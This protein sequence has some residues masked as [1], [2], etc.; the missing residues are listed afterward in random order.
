TYERLLSQGRVLVMYI[1]QIMLPL[2]RWMPFYYDW[3][4]P[5]RGLMQPWTTL[6]ALLVIAFLFTAAL[7]FRTRS[8]VFS[9]GILIFFASHFVSSNVVGLEL[10]F[11][12]R[13]NFALI[14]AALAA[15][16]AAN[17]LVTRFGVPRNTLVLVCGG[18]LIFL[19][20]ST[21]IRS[22][23]WSNPIQLSRKS[24]EFAPGSSRAWNSLCVGYFEL[25]GGYVEKNPH[26]DK[27][28]EACRRG[29]DSNSY[30]VT[31]LTNLVVFKTIRGDVSNNDWNRFLER[32][33]HVAMSPENTLA[34]WVI[35]NNASRGVPLDDGGV[36]EVIAIAEKRIQFRPVE[37]A[38]IGYFLLDRKGGSDAAYRFLSRAVINS[39]VESALAEEIIA[40]MRRQGREAFARRLE[41]QARERSHGAT[42]Q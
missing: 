23:I 9:A 8:P 7:R 41:L 40:D 13:N 19:S 27:A 29:A 20:G 42:F 3:L 24:T 22:E 25:G 18:G 30:S 39:P 4:Q 5:S 14:G 32:F 6:P 15:A 17:F 16:G 12:H 37:N 31:S 34:V 33:Q 26:L 10:A 35:I 38:A 1:G 11:E 21:F 36:A 28:I 2:P